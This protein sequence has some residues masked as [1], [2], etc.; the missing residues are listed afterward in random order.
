VERVDADV[1]HAGGIGTLGPGSSRATK[2]Q[3][4][5][6]ISDLGF[7]QEV[8]SFLER[9]A[10]FDVLGSVTEPSELIRRLAHADADVTVL[11]PVMGRE[12]S[13]PAAARRARSVLLVAEE[14]TVPVLREA[15]DAGAHG[16]FAWPEERLDLAEAI[17]R[18]PRARAESSSTRGRVLS[19][20]GARGGAGATFLATHLAAAL[21]D[22]G[23]RTV[24]VD[25]DPEF[26]D[27]TVALGVSNSTEVRTVASLDRVVNELSSDH[28]EDALYPHPRGFSV[29]LGPAAENRSSVTHDG[30]FPACI[31]L[32]AGSFDVVVALAPRVL[33]ASAMAVLGMADAVVVVVT[34]DLFALYGAR[35][36][37]ATI[38]PSDPSKRCS[39][40]INRA[41]RSEVAIADVERILGLKPTAVVRFDPAVKRAQDRGQLLPARAGRAGRDVA[42]L[43]RSLVPGAERTGREARGRKTS[44]R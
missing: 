33:D 8:M 22:R 25:A 30:L 12:L 44:G 24:V 27:L 2:A 15:I 11:C 37:L 41:A 43:A 20:Y 10:R 34:L 23:E 1:G 13:H 9:D 39:V 36:A 32:L 7:H 18:A 40:V 16:V 19:V 35:R 21:A 17:V 29:L 5:I 6:G 14:M 42:A 3:V 38:H 4:L 28:L 26:A 31:A